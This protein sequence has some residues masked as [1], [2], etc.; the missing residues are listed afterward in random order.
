M[1]KEVMMA[2]KILAV[3]LVILVLIFVFQNI[4]VVKV[5]FLAW[6]ISMPRAL[7]IFATLIIGIIVG[8][9]ARRPKK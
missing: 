6:D 2:G 9:L 8:R 1:G 4:E 3:I 5:S 7:M